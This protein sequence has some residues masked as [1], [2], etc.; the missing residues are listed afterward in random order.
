MPRDALR[1]YGTDMSSQRWSTWWHSLGLLDFITGSVHDEA[2]CDYRMQ[3]RRVASPITELAL[4]PIVA[5]TPVQF[6]QPTLQPPASAFE[7]AGGS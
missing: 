5:Q 2:N 1:S 7:R 6:L 4:Q 3:A